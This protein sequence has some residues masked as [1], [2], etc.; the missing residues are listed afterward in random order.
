MSERVEKVAA[1]LETSR[2]KE[3]VRS[4]DLAVVQR[5]LNEVL[6]RLRDMENRLRE[7]ERFKDVQESRYRNPTG[8]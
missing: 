6:D 7:V 3:E 4:G 8:R 5:M 2:K 1:G